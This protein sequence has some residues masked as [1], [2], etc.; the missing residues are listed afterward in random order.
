M[1]HL[2]GVVALA[3]CGLALPAAAQQE[4]GF[5]DT[6]I[7]PQ[8]A[9]NSNGLALTSVCAMVQQDRANY[10]RFN[11]PD[12]YDGHDLFF[13]SVEARAVISSNCLVRE[14][15]SDYILGSVARGE[16][17]YIHVTIFG[18]GNRVMGVGIRE[19]AG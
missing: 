15:I 11:R 5:Y 4:I 10:H 2:I 14:G 17:A 12:R 7:S 3:Y 16:A 1:R 19:G 8:D 13:D 18:Q 9:F 6:W